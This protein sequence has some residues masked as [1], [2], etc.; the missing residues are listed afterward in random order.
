MALAHAALNLEAAGFAVDAALGDVQ[1]VEKSLPDG[2]ASGVKLP[3]PGSHNAEGGFNVFSTSLSGD[4]TLIPQHKYAPVLDVV[5]GKATAS[6][7]TAQGYQVRYGSSWMMTVSFTD[8][9][10]KA[11]GI[12]TYSESSNVL[13]PS[14]SDQSELYSTQKQLRPLL[15]TEAEIQASLESTTELTYQR[16]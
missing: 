7:L 8:D 4:D 10:P 14:F 9:G 12:L 16:N 3:W 5:T 11:K 1:F 6:G 2:S 15:F 13:S